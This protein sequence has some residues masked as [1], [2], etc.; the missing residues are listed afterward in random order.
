MTMTSNDQRQKP[1]NIAETDLEARTFVGD[2]WR[3]FRRHRLA[4][5]A[6]GVL[7]DNI[8]LAS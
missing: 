5:I 4:M 3:Q 6:I 7:S 2:A 8:D 1:K